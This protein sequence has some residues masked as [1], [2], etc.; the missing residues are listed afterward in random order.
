M[1][2]AYHIRRMHANTL[3]RLRLF[4]RYIENLARAADSVNLGVWYDLGGSASVVD[5]SCS[6]LLL[7][8]TWGRVCRIDQQGLSGE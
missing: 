2:Q 1:R 6:N 7:A 3:D 4:I 5:S 8:Y